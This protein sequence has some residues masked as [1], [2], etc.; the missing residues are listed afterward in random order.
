V[1]IKVPYVVENTWIVYA[2]TTMEAMMKY[3]ERD[4]NKWPIVRQATQEDLAQLSPL[5]PSG[6]RHAA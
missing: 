2:V 4:P 1:F 5:V 3:R 6:H